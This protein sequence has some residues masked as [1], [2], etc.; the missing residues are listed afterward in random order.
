MIDKNLFLHD[1][2]VVSI[3]KN[4]APYLK[5]WLDYHLV[6]GV[7]HFYLYDNDSP[8]NQLEVATPYIEAGLVDYFKVPGKFMQMVAY[9][10]AVKNFKFQSRYLAFI[11]GD[12]FIFPKTNRGVVEIVDEILSQN[13]DAGG[14][15]VN[16]HQFGSNGEIQ[17]DYSRGVLER[18]TRRA[19]NNWII[20][21][22]ENNLPGGNAHVKTIA[23]P[24]TIDFLY[25]PHS[26]VYFNGFY[27]VNENGGVVNGPFNNPVTADK[28]VMNHYSV[29]SREEYA[30]KVNRGAADHNTYHM[31]YFDINNR[32]EEFDDSILIYRATRARNF[33]LPDKSRTD[34]KL[35]NAL[36]K[37]LAPMLLPNT[38]ENFYSDKMETF[39]TCRAVSSYLKS[40]IT[41]EAQ[42][43]FFEE[44]SLV[45][46]L[47]T[48]ESGVNFT[49][50][51]IFLR[52]LP[53]F[54]HL[55]YPVVE[56]LRNISL[57][58][59]SQMMDIMRVNSM[60]KN[61]SELD[62]IRQLLKE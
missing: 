29:K 37:N 22:K 15:A 33:R 30:R 47:R 14:L 32:N 38:P 55:H 24:R 3:L 5:E 35:L 9:N 1:L 42:A 53:N 6:A 7:D 46:I 16:L 43:N 4:E 27:A 44:T 12:E 17:A 8:D 45:A 59:I 11:D 34:E 36:M 40:R 57:Q 19:P 41:N 23:N 2:S 20:P 31:E 39:L 60:W 52:D 28:I 48:L 51:Q 13:D 50:L 25:L 58:I 21:L 26:A 62:Y 49:D 10:D 61:Y 54:L 18:F 56:E